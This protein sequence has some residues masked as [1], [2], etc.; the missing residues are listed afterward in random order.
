MG[1]PI[2]RVQTRLDL[3][4]IVLAAS[5]LLT[6]AIA[7]IA[8]ED[9]TASHAADAAAV[10]LARVFA[11]DIVEASAA[12]RLADPLCQSLLRHD[13]VRA[14]RL[15]GPDGSP[16]CTASVDP[17]YDRL[18]V[19]DKLRG[20]AAC[21]RRIAVPVG[22]RGVDLRQVDFSLGESA[23][24]AGATSASLL[25]AIT[26]TASP[27]LAALLPFLVPLLSVTAVAVLLGWRYVRQQVLH[28]L[29]IIELAVGPDAQ[30]E[31]LTCL[32]RE[33]VSRDD[34]LGRIARGIT[35]LNRELTQWRRRAEHVERQLDTRVA[36]RTH[37]ITQELE[38]TRRAL[39]RDP[40]TGLSN[41]RL[42]EDRFGEIFQA[43]RDHG[44]DL[45]V[46]L[47]DIDRFK[48]LND[49]RGHQAGDEVLQFAGALLRQFI[50]ADDLAVRLGGDEFLLI[51]P[52]VHHDHAQALAQ[53]VVALFRQYATLI[54][55]VTVRPGLSAG[56]ASLKRDGAP[57]PEALIAC[58]D[59]RMYQQKQ[60]NRAI[61]ARAAAAVSAPESAPAAST[62]PPPPL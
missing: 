52:G 18:F 40:L 15:S 50:R 37:Q 34:A 2:G 19:P 33:I 7:A 12:G 29:Q 21:V 14:V 60:L 38:K 6:A 54:P 58:A 4:L 9:Q 35:H 13:A 36:A 31:L 28:P 49:T 1:T 42:F 26:S 61:P 23:G 56:V 51:L 22:A 25:L 46:V 30:R 62:S 59:Q 8:R 17:L 32:E 55:G 24:P 45:S 57:S 11:Q 10:E 48:L 39:W 47:V 27:R 53:R 16:T 43:Q 5:A 44:A 3:L 20:A 41:R